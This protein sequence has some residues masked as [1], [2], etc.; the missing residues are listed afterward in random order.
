MGNMEHNATKTETEVYNH[1]IL[2]YLHSK[3]KHSE[4]IGM[5]F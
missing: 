4:V 2:G 3:E 5:K 1:Q